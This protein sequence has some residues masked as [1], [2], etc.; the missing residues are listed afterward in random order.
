MVNPRPATLV[1]ILAGCQAQFDFP[2][3]VDADLIVVF[4]RT[5]IEPDEPA[6][7]VLPESS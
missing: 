2:F 7:Y 5:G 3:A 6:L 1:R 4:R